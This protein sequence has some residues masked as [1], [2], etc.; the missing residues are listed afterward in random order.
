M[1]KKIYSFIALL[2]SILLLFGVFYIDGAN[3]KKLDK[4]MKD[5]NDVETIIR[6]RTKSETPI[7]DNILFN[8]EQLIRIDNSQLFFSLVK[9]EE[10][11]YPTVK[12]EYDLKERKHVKLIAREI[13]ID[14]SFIENNKTLEIITYDKEYYHV[15]YISYT[16]LPIMNIMV[17][18]EEISTKEVVA[19]FSFYDN[20]VDKID[21]RLSRMDGT[22]RVRGT[23]SSTY[24]KKGYRIEFTDK[25]NLLNLRN[26]DDYVLYAAYNDPEKVRNV[27]SSN[28]W[29]DSCAS[30]N[31]LDIKMGME[32]RYIELFINNK[33]WG[34]YALGYPIDEKQLDIEKNG[35][36][37]LENY[38]KK[39]KK[40]NPEN[41][42]DFEIISD[43]GYTPKS[44]NDIKKLW[45]PITDYYNVLLN[46]T[47]INIREKI[48]INNSIDI[49]LFFN[50][51]QGVDNVVKTKGVNEWLY[52]IYLVSKNINNQSVMFYIPW[53]MDRTWGKAFGDDLT[54]WDE[55][56]DGYDIDYSFNVESDVLS[57]GKLLHKK[58][59]NI[60]NEIKEK[61]AQLRNSWWSNESITKM[62]NGYEEDIYNSGAFLRDK[63]RWPDGLYNNKDTKLQ[64]FKEYVLN[65]FSYLDKK[66]DYK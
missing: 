22:I 41:L 34:L 19:S 32:Y 21:N 18:N 45:N 36:D 47:P 25:H 62:L 38:Y 57:V 17:A 10:N 2:V 28:L 8:Q 55:K 13:E 35:I 58:D 31:Q 14:D 65:R 48:D 63:N 33:Y 40:N 50:L 23:S 26:D 43:N 61:Y 3:S 42:Y 52:N 12:W 24:P 5:N 9:K 60:L 54:I 44:Q 20:T 51:I 59:A 6:S 66:Y 1:K 4:L 46:K 30:D 16:T 27:F 49:Y 11:Y 37:V 39:D 15:D 29:F 53:D 64:V 7:V 56:Y